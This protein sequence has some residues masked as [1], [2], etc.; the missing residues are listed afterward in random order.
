M[1]VA[2]TSVKL[3]GLVVAM[4]LFGMGPGAVLLDELKASWE[5]R[6]AEQQREKDDHAAIVAP[7]GEEP[8]D[9]QSRPHHVHPLDEVMLGNASSIQKH[10]INQLS[11]EEAHEFVTHP[12]SPMITVSRNNTNLSTI[13]AHSEGHHNEERNSVP[14]TI[15]W[16]SFMLNNPPST[17]NRR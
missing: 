3:A 1:S 4:G 16:L 12:F 6:R 5:K 10:P 8:P 15:P 9:P 13:V 2:S 11:S 17:S 14:T 7:P